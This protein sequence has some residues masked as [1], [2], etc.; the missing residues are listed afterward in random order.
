MARR[1]PWTT[2]QRAPQPGDVWEEREPTH[3]TSRSIRPTAQTVTGYRASGREVWV[4][5]MG[6]P[7]AGQLAQVE[8]R[9]RRRKIR[10][11][12]LASAL[13]SPR[14]VLTDRRGQVVEQLALPR[15]GV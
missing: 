1:W 10:M 3:A 14:W 5:S 9:T 4:L 15:R 12:V 13:R 7:G 8:S 6:P 2:P 11:E